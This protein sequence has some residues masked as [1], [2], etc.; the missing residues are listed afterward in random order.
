VSVTDAPTQV[1]DR[2]AAL[3]EHIRAFTALYEE[4]AY[5]VYNVALRVTCEREAA[6]QTAERAFL[7]QVDHE[8]DQV[9]L[10]ASTAR[11]ALSLAPDSPDPHGA[12]D[13]ACETL[14]AVNAQLPPLERAALAL[15]ALIEADDGTIAQLLGITPDAVA[16]LL[17]HGMARFAELRGGTQ[18]EVAA[19]IDGWLLA[20]P[21]PGL[22]ETIYPAFHR[23][24]EAQLETRPS[25]EG[26]AAAT[27]AT[28]AMPA[29]A[30]PERTSRFSRA[31]ARAR[32]AA[33]TIVVLAVL[34]GGGYAAAA[35]LT[36]GGSSGA[37]HTLGQ[38]SLPPG[39]AG[40][41][42]SMSP[43][44]LDRLR[45][46][47]IKAQAAGGA[48]HG[49]PTSATSVPP[50]KAKQAALLKRAKAMQRVAK[51]KEA[52]RERAIARQRQ[53]AASHSS[54]ATP[55]P[56]PTPS[57]PRASTAPTTTS[58]ATGNTPTTSTSTTT[59]SSTTS[60]GNGAPT[61]SQADQSC[62]LNPDTGTYVCPK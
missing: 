54:P 40:G 36:G 34:G 23:R 16:R 58:G 5:V 35:A 13:S 57:K 14:L 45:Q 62:L 44:E 24:V 48:G 32:A 31:R 47:E 42:G 46:R 1:L 41:D 55:P 26:N 53:K 10:I 17:D 59:P 7:A 51:L 61:K 9:R 27:R 49:G 30:P 4:A 28:T 39:A 21:P 2:S 38:R 52:K 19:A 50:S 56:T 8:N 11:V 33:W 18:E 25:G 22:W 6:M 3:Q 37:Q 15:G 12:G 20:E 43:Q 60:S 29:L